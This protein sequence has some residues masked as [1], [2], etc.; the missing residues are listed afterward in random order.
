ML[1]QPFD[2]R[3]IIGPVKELV[4]PTFQFLESIL[5]CSENERHCTNKIKAISQARLNADLCWKIKQKQRRELAKRHSKTSQNGE[6]TLPLALVTTHC[7]LAFSIVRHLQP[8][9]QLIF[10][11]WKAAKHMPIEIWRRKLQRKRNSYL[12]T[13]FP[14]LL[15]CNNQNS[16]HGKDC[17]S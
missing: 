7:H 4:L 5:Q 10:S 9:L 14:F 3:T 2:R 8:Q 12:E 13:Q 1:P 15:L 16:S 17:F 11:N 6:F